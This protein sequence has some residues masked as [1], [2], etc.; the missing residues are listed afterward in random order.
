MM[1]FRVFVIAPIIGMGLVGIL[2]LRMSA[3]PG[4]VGSKNRTKHTPILVMQNLRVVVM[5][6]TMG[7]LLVVDPH[8][9][10]PPFLK[11]KAS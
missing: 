1:W 2:S 5:V 8:L 6:T 10:L 9:L 7:P 3:G 4:N 11:T